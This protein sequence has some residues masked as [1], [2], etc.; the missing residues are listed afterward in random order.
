M[1][2]ISLSICLELGPL[3]E[4]F[5]MILKCSAIVIIIKLIIEL[6][7]T[8]WYISLHHVLE[9]TWEQAESTLIEVL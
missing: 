4:T 1:V 8:Y 5:I 7:L 9:E 2:Q 6:Y 3:S